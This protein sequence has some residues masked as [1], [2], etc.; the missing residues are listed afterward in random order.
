VVGVPTLEVKRQPL[1]DDQQI[2]PPPPGRF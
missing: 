1:A 2:N